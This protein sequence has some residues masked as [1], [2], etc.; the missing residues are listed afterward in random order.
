MQ[1]GL[2]SVIIPTRNRAAYLKL[3]VESV[4]RQTYQNFE[5]IVIDDGSVD[6]TKDV[7]KSFDDRLQYFFQ[8]S[9]GVSAARNLGISKARGE[10]I[11]FLDDDD[12]YLP[13]RLAIAVDYLSHHADVSWVCSGFSFIDAEGNALPRDA[14]LP[15]KTKIT[16]HD[17]AMFT[18][19]STCSVTV[20]RTVLD[21][22]GGFPEGSRASEDYHLWAKVMKLSNGGTIQKNLVFYRQH[23]GNTTFPF[24]VLVRENARIIDEIMAS[25][26]SGLM[27]RAVYMKNLKRIV[28]D[29]LKYRHNYLQYTIFSLYRLFL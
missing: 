28:G 12:I 23:A 22:V 5:I 3:A 2:V 1:N 8:T 15:E 29:T 10:Y 6:H 27:P 7:I 19:I 17:I 11:A 24:Y 13:E 25:N 14:I 20:K 26:T 16:L 9:K 18:F 21:K 4:Y